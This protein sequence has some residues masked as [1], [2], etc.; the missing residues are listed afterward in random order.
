[1]PLF[2][3]DQFGDLQITSAKLSASAVTAGKINTGAINASGLFLAGVVNSA[4]LATDAVTAGKIATGG[5]SVAT[6]FVA[7]VVDSAAIAANAVTSSELATN[8]VISG[9]IAAGAISSSGNFV[10]GVVDET[11]LGTAAVTSVKLATSAVTAGKIG[12]GGINASDQFAGSVVDTAALANAA[13]TPAK[14][15]LSQVWAFTALPSVNSDPVGANDLVRKSYADAIATGLSDFKNSARLATTG[16]LP[17]S[18][19]VGNVLTAAANGSI[20]NQDGVAPVV[21]NRILVK[22][23]GAGTSLVNGIYDVTDLGSAGT[24]WILTRSSDADT[25]AEV[26]SGMYLFVDE[27]TANADTAWVLST[28]DPITLNTTP[29]TFAKFSSLSDL[30]AGA[31]IL[32]TSSTLSIDLAATAPGLEFDVGG[33]AGKLRVLVDPS[34]AVERNANGIAVKLEAATPSLAIVANELGLKIDGTTNP[35]GG[36]ASVLSSSANGVGVNVDDSTLEATAAGGSLRVK[37]SG[38][39]SAKLAN[40][41]V[42]SNQIADDSVT[43][44][45]TGW[46]PGDDY[47]AG[48]DITSTF[49]LTNAITETSHHPGVIVSRNG[50][51]IKR[52]AAAPSGLDEY[53]VSGTGPTTVTLGAALPTGQTLEMGYAY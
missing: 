1:M 24:P 34:G 27:G 47:F 39:T 23:E 28:N 41:A 5:I 16:A 32:D 3:T 22:N 18:T 11:A 6:Q 33:D 44:A 50:Q 14:A 21:G 46:L 26:T 52:V 31:G 17:A 20:P 53:S 4:A 36:V 10:A 43:L 13:V 12:V 9:K 48:D 40:S 25:S 38:I 42:G 19:L 51:R 7:G 37:D 2:V 29:L 30:V 35:G 49:N 15:D 8:A 45:K